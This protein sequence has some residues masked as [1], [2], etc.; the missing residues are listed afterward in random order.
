M[1]GTTIWRARLKSP[2]TPEEIHW[3]TG[4]KLMA[5]YYPISN[6]REFVWTVGASEAHLQ[7]AGLS[8]RHGPS[9]NQESKENESPDHNAQPP[10]SSRAEEGVAPV[11]PGLTPKEVIL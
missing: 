3:M 7:A 8:V 2:D 9:R 10:S 11:K 6:A 4:G 5:A 1:Q